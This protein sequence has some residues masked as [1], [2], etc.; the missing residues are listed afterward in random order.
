M[1]SS[2]FC[3]NITFLYLNKKSI[4]CKT[5]SFLII[6]F[7][8]ME[9]VNS[10]PVVQKNQNISEQDCVKNLQGLIRFICTRV[11]P[12][13]MKI[14][15]TTCKYSHKQNNIIIKFATSEK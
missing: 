4:L 6:A 3:M 14:I 10:S 7:I 11:A 8:V 13:K 9:F 12:Y 5:F 2:Y 15:P 1:V